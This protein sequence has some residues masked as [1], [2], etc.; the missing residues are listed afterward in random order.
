MQYADQLTVAA[1]HAG[2]PAVSV[3]G[4]LDEQSL[5]IGIQFIGS[6]Y[7]EAKLLRIGR[8]YELGTQDEPWRGIKP[9]AVRVS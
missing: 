2:V 6:D 8:S 9:S 1:N 7:S 4:G 5:P 3:P